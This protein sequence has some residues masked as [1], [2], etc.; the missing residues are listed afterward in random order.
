MDLK[1]KV[2]SAILSKMVSPKERKFGVEIESF[3][4]KQDTLERIPVNHSDYYSAVELLED[5]KNSIPNSGQFSYSLE[6]GGQLEWASGPSISLWDIKDQFSRN[7]LIQQNLCEK[8]KIDIGYFSVEPI[9]S[10]LDIDL[11]N[12]NKYK[13]MHDLFLKRGTLGAWMMRNTTSIQVNIDFTDSEDASQMAFIADAIQPLVSIIFSNSPFMNGGPTGENLRWKIWENT[14][15]SRCGTLYEHSMNDVDQIVDKYAEWLLTRDTIF[16]DNL[17]DTF[18]AFNGNFGDMISLKD[19]DRLIFSA[20][21]Q[22]FTHVRFK[23]VLEI[24][25]ADR[26]QKGSELSPAAFAIGLL[27]AQ[28]TRDILLNEIISWSDKDRE[29]LSR[30]AKELSFDNLVPKGKSIR[31]CLEFLSQ[32]ALDGLD[33]R[34]DYFEIQNE[35]P[36]LESELNHIL[37]HGTATNRIIDEYNKSGQSLKSFIKEKYL[38]SYK[39]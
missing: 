3:Y 32:L 25:A 38:D 39:S 6:P 14:D 5:V 17:D 8:N 1:E 2:I 33:E 31:F 11:I 10:P 23:N 19:D 34:A 21:R 26:Q 35:R 12:S 36:F 29:R 13:L 30:S 9:S 22:I 27:T 16:L 28:R 18:D 7:D 4:Y 20:F 24:R 37:S 15:N